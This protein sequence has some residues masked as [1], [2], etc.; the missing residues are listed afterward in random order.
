MS[1]FIPYFSIEPDEAFILQFIPMKVYY[2][3]SK[4]RNFQ[5]YIGFSL[6]E[7]KGSFIFLWNIAVYLEVFS[8]R[9][10][11]ED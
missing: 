4:P 3:N 9:V 2:I 10:R 6:H 7:G 1:T 5:R 11:V 8:L